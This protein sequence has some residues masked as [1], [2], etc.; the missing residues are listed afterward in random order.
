MILSFKNL[1]SLDDFHDLHPNARLIFKWLINGGWP[2]DFPLMITRIAEPSADQKTAIHTSGPPHRAFDL[3]T[4]GLSSIEARRIESRINEAWI[5]DPTRP[6]LHVAL[7]H[8]AGSG[9]HMHIQV[10]DATRSSAG[11]DT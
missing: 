9:H 3:R 5:Y 10:H 6:N 7:Y 4:M 8:D 11:R 1:R 2:V